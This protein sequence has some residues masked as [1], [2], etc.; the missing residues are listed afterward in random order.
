MIVFNPPL[1]PRRFLPNADQYMTDI[2]VLLNSVNTLRHAVLPLDL[3]GRT[4][5]VLVALR[6]HL[7]LSILDLRLPE[8]YHPTPEDIDRFRLLLAVELFGFHQIQKLVIQ[9][10][11]LDW[12]VIANLASLE[13]LE[14]LHITSQ[15]GGDGFV[16]ALLNLGNVPFINGFNRL[17]TIEVD[18]NNTSLWAVEMLQHIFPNVQIL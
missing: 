11:L 9:T 12:M 5:S 1:H 4:T 2:V 3:S 18:I 8:S 15:N 14:H 10:K 17:T 13:G 7:Q 16:N 6:G